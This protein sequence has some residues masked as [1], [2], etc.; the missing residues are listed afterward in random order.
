MPRMRNTSAC[1]CLT[2]FMMGSPFLPICCSANPTSS[3]M[4]STCST[5]SPVNAEKN[6]VG[7]IPRM[8]SCVVF[9]SVGVASYVELVMFRPSPGWMMLPTTRP[10]ASANVVMTM[11]YSSASPPILPTVAALAIEPMPTTI[12]QKMI[13]AIIILMSATKPLPIGSSAT[14]KSGQIR[15]IVAPSTTAMI[16]AM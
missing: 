13:G 11:K 9:A 8:N 16:T 7:M 15:P 14:P 6:V 4:N 2:A 10:I 1:R 5:L 3:A 12:V